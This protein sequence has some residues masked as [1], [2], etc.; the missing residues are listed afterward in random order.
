MLPDRALTADHAERSRKWTVLTGAID[1]SVTE[2]SSAGQGVSPLYDFVAGKTDFMSNAGLKNG[3]AAASKC[4]RRITFI[5]RG[6]ELADRYLAPISFCLSL[7]CEAFELLKLE[8]FANRSVCMQ[9]LNHLTE[10]QPT[11]SQIAAC[12]REQCPWTGRLSS[13]RPTA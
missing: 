4:Q 11:P 12:R 6:F 13:A 2:H 8:G 1:P 3:R 7:T 9:T 10:T 5:E